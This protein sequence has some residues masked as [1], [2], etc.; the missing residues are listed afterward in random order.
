MIS[1]LLSRLSP[2]GERARLPILTFHRVP[3]EEDW[4]FPGEATAA[5][6]EQICRWLR[7]WFDVLPLDTAMNRLKQGD[8]PAGACAITFDDGYADNHDV[9]LPILQRLG[10]SATFFIATGYTDGSCMWNDVVLDA[11]RRTRRDSIDLSEVLAMEG[12]RLALGS[13]EDRRAAA[14]RIVD[15]IKYEAEERRMACALRC[16]AALD[17]E[18]CRDLMMSP[19]Q[20]QA[21]ARGGMSLGA[22]TVRHPILKDLPPDRVRAELQQSRSELESLVQ[23][24]VGLF[25]YPNGRPD[26]DYD[27][28][29]VAVVRDLGFDAA[30]TTSQGVATR[31]SDPY[32]VPRIM[33]WAPDRWR[34]AWQLAGALGRHAGQEARA[35]SAAVAA[36]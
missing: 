21:M 20:L 22:H 18:P 10:L 32:Q 25:A 23:T 26:V 5:R 1:F 13:H 14:H 3:V 7:A 24:R 35:S 36:C 31:G 12:A 2:S 9:A 33:P 8:L 28:T 27:L 15:G 4:M 11:L 29:T 6:F 34:F 19:K 17:V 16:A 30:V